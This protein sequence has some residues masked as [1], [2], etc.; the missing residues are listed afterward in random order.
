MEDVIEF[1]GFAYYRKRSPYLGTQCAKE[2]LKVVE[3]FTNEPFDQNNFA[4]VHDLLTGH[5]YIICCCE[6]GNSDS[7]SENDNYDQ[8]I[9]SHYIC[10]IYH[11]KHTPTNKIFGV[12]CECVKKIAP[13]LGEKLVRNICK[14][15]GNLLP[16]VRSNIR[17]R[18]YCSGEC[19][20]KQ[21]HTYLQD[22]KNVD[23]S[24]LLGSIQRRRC[25][26]CK[27][28]LEEKQQRLLYQTQCKTC[29]IAEKCK[30]S[31]FECVS[32]GRKMP[33]D[34]YSSCYGCFSKK[35]YKKLVN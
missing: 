3:Y 9:C 6:E 1:D 15:C 35:K 26:K 27:K 30:N 2:F 20:E 17:K 19:E 13:E 22:I 16:N 33:N 8:C 23:K 12:G 28:V 10:Y 29:F 25:V 34:T 14:T 32:C 18:G 5:P 24:K 21:P 4:P 7:D 11:I 31:P